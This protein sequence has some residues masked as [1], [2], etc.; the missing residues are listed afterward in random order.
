MEAKYQ[1]CPQGRGPE[2]VPGEIWRSAELGPA[3][4][5]AVLL[6]SIGVISDRMVGLDS[7]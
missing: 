2:T 4:E 7:V 6:N 5:A 1:T 3:I